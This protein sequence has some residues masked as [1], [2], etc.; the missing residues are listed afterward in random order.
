MAVSI[1]GYVAR[2][3]GET[4]WVSELDFE[5]FDQRR[6]EAGCT[7]MGRTTYDEV[8]SMEGITTIVVTRDPDAHRNTENTF[9]VESPSTAL[10]LAAARGHDKILLA[11][12]GATNGAFLKAGLI[13]E[14][15]LSVHPIALGDGTKL[16]GTETIETPLTLLDTEK[17][18]ENIVQLHYTVA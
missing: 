17:L 1:D 7:V 10:E 18:D 15:F 11:G 13:N 9:F 8:G 6:K 14:I 16:F 2:A 12:G 5:L 3:N 4:T